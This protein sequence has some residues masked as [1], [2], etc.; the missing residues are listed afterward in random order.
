MAGGVTCPLASD[1]LLVV[2]LGKQLINTDVQFILQSYDLDRR[3]SAE[4]LIRCV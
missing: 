1:D 2:S 4:K 3:I